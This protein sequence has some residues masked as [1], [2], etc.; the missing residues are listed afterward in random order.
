MLVLSPFSRGGHVA[1]G[2]FDHTSQLRFLEER[3]DISVPNISEWRR[4]TVGDLTGTLRMGDSR[5]SLPVLPPTADDSAAY[6]ASFGCDNTD[7]LG[8]DGAQAP[9][10]Q[11][12]PQVMP[13]QER[14][15]SR[16]TAP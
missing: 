9:Y 14:A 4:R 7:F 3:F 11:P 16:A 13:S 8:I 6:L 2:T 1:S 5:L 15:A 12:D 10:P